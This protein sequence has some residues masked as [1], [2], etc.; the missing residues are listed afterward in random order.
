[1]KV[2]GI[3]IAVIMIVLVAGS[4]GDHRK[5]AHAHGATGGQFAVCAIICAVIGIFLLSRKK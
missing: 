1:M 5:V 2:I 3:V 4:T